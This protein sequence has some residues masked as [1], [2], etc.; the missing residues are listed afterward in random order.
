[1]TLS[2]ITYRY[3]YDLTAFFLSHLKRKDKKEFDLLLTRVKSRVPHILN[4]K[5]VFDESVWPP[6][7]PEL[8]NNHIVF[9]VQLN[10][11]VEIFRFSMLVD[12]GMDQDMVSAP[13]L[14]VKVA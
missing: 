10:S 14:E 7:G 8:Y 3:I 9:M 6:D 12:N 4:F 1:M 2:Q 5:Y 11:Q 13:L